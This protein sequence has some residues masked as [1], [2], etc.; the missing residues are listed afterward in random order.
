[1]HGCLLVVFL[2]MLGFP[3]IFQHVSLVCHGFVKDRITVSSSFSPSPGSSKYKRIALGFYIC[4]LQSSAFTSSPLSFRVNLFRRGSGFLPQICPLTL[5]NSEKSLQEEAVSLI[6]SRLTVS[7]ADIS[8]S[9][10]L[11]SYIRYLTYINPYS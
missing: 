9:Q 4:V 6:L 2:K 3:W 7:Q 10:T 5:S 1:M 8:F 11:T